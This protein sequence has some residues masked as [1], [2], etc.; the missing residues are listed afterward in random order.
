MSRYPANV[1]RSFRRQLNRQIDTSIERTHSRRPNEQ[2]RRSKRKWPRKINDKLFL[3]TF[4][5]PMS[6]LPP[7]SAKNQNKD[8]T[9]KNKEKN[10][11]ARKEKRNVKSFRFYFFGFPLC[12]VLF[13]IHFVLYWCIVYTLHILVSEIRAHELELDTFG[14]GVRCVCAHS[15]RETFVLDIYILWFS[16]NSMQSRAFVVC[17]FRKNCQKVASTC[18]SL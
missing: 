2:I 6:S 18:G 4:S 10:K 8:S 16:R 14:M 15:K 3:I 1:L 7:L 13:P 17:Y 11:C 12:F 9:K 5:P